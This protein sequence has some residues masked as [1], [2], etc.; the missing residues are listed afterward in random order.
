[1]TT[2]ALPCDAEGNY[3]P[4]GT[5]PPPR[6]TMPAVQGDWAPFES[7]L[8][9]K[10]ADI[11]YRRAAMSA[12]NI[13]AILELWAETAALL[14]ADAPFESH[15]HLYKTIDASTVGNVP[16]ESLVISIPQND[17]DNSNSPEIGWKK[18]S[19]E[20][21]YRDPDAVVSM[22]L[23]NADFDGQFDLR[24]YVELDPS[25]KRQWNNVMSGNIAWR[26][27]VRIAVHL[28]PNT[29]SLMTWIPA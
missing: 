5:P 8:Q 22:M 19:Y 1:M 7:E 28:L 9:F 29:I 10:V 11:F 16:W 20:V 2:V 3:L 25:G 17:S 15:D 21:W 14:G 26:R 12:S 13:D 23:E 27:C 24:P 6:V 18:K 4:H